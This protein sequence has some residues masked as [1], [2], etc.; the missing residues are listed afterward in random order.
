[1]HAPLRALPLLV[2]LALLLGPLVGCGGEAE[3]PP[4]EDSAETAFDGGQPSTP[5]SVT[6]VLVLGNSIAA[7]HGLAPSQAF[8][9]LLQQKADSAGWAVKVVNAGVSGETTAGGL[10]RL[11]WHLRQR[12]DV[13]VVE[14]GGND[15]LRGT[16]LVATRRNLQAIIDSTRGRYPKADVVLTGMQIPPN[17]GSDYTERFRDL[18]PELAEAND[19]MLVPF[20]LED[21]GGRPEMNQPDGIHPTAE[22]QQIVAQNVW[23][24][25]APLLRARQ[26]E[27]EAAPSTTAP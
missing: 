5:D 24:V 7:G 15:G 14:L 17:M 23:E 9:A 18:Y 8:P 12:I 16:P 20:L 21:V 22:G 27:R 2:A 1:M 10:R 13:L 11:E 4:A 3:T 19:V 6:T 26:E 25:L